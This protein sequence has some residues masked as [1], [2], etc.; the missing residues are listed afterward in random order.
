M[1]IFD[2]FK[3][4]GKSEKDA[5]ASMPPKRFHA[6][7][8]LNNP[9]L[10][11]LE[12]ARFGLFR[13]LD[14]SYHGCLVEAV[15]TGSFEQCTY[16]GLIEFSV[17]GS[18]LS[19]ESNQC[20][21]RKVGWGLVFKHNGESSIRSV[22][23]LIEPMRC[24]DSAIFLPAS[25]AKDGTQSRFRRRYQGDGPFDL[26]V[27]QNEAGKIIFIMATVRRLSEYGCVVWDNGVVVTKK[28]VDADGVGARMSQTE[29]VDTA[30]VYVSILTC[31][32]LKF[33][34]GGICAKILTDWLGEQ[35]IIPLAK[36]S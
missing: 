28:T 14:L 2:F 13:V 34:D 33:P 26:M 12:H 32:G 3:S 5:A 11:L 15:G 16:P 6:R 35:S 1:G 27:E 29:E 18:I 7:Y 30:L 4:K 21:R 24:G 22:G 23:T 36:S 20:Q 10:C 9:D 31:L 19:L 25:T 17:A 8:K